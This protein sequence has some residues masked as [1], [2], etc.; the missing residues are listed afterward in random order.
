VHGIIFAELKKFVESRMGPQAWHRVL[1][2]A[3]L[4]G[5]VYLATASYPEDE[6][7]RLVSAA[8]LATGRD[9]DEWLEEFGEF[10]AS[11][12]LAVYRPLI[13]PEWRTLDVL[14][15]TEEM[16]RTVLRVRDPGATAVELHTRRAGPDEVRLSY[17][18]PRRLCAVARGL[19]RG[20][21]RHYGE[22]VEVSEIHCMRDGAASC[23]IRVRKTA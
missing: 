16:I 14:Q 5:G 19:A 1:D 11:D 22:R 6:A 8:A 21:A 23:E 15:H 7:H 17:S 18:S 20:L 10:I 12:L 4:E 2:E 13:R 3:G 9:E